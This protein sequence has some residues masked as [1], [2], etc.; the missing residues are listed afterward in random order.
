MEETQ[1]KSS[2]EYVDGVIKLSAKARV[3]YNARLGYE[4]A[5]KDRGFVERFR[6]LGGD[7]KRVLIEVDTPVARFTYAGYGDIM[8]QE[9]HGRVREYVKFHCPRD[10]NETWKALYWFGDFTV[11]VYI[12]VTKNVRG[13]R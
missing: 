13:G 10:F 11:N 12:P 7:R 8:R 1:V 4:L 3:W 6:E 2:E 9:K 5:I